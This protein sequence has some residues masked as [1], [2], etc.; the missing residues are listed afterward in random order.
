MTV[1]KGGGEHWIATGIWTLSRRPGHD[2]AMPFWNFRILTLFTMTGASLRHVVSDL[3]IMMMV[4]L[5]MRCTTSKS[6]YT[7]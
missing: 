2:H 5:E 3:V 1:E 4:R 6:I 7:C